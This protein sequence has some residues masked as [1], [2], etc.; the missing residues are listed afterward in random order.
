MTDRQIVFVFTGEFGYELL[1]WHAKI[2]KFAIENPGCEIVVASSA[3]TS[4]LYKEIARFIPL[5]SI[6]C[7]SSG[8]ADSYFLRHTQFKRDSLYDVLSA[9]N[10]RRNIRFFLDEILGPEPKRKYIFSDQLNKLGNLT[11]GATRW[12]PRV[13]L[14]RTRNFQEIYDRLPYQ[15]NHYHQLIPSQEA[16]A[17]VKQKLMDLG[18]SRKFIAFQS[19]DREVFLKKRR[20]EANSGRIVGLLLDELPCVEI[21]FSQFR[22]SD[23]QSL[24]V[25]S[26]KVIYCDSLDDQIAIISLASYC[27]FISG[28][29][30][31]SLHYVPPLC[32]KNVY[33]IVSS[34][35][36]SN[37]SIYLWNKEVNIFG[38]SIIPISSEALLSDARYLSSIFKF[39]K[40]IL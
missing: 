2:Y 39:F 25:N 18:V 35:I 8:I 10:R 11:F 16:V 19:A 15:E 36:M 21:K 40:S 38:G 28:G 3:A 29:D 26:S 5:N 37:S 13:N 27:I 31:R 33:S 7:F 6:S 24:D 30:F 22:T 32:G 1:N 12:A 23:T 4:V 17:K 34:S 9:I 14:F 20:L